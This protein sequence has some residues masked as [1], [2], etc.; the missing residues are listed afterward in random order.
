MK[1]FLILLL[2][3]T[4]TSL[5]SQEKI[6]IC[7]EDNCVPNFEPRAQFE[8]VYNSGIDAGDFNEE[9]ITIDTEVNASPRNLRM[10]IN[11][12]DFYTNVEADID[13]RPKTDEFDAANLI[14]ITDFL[15][16][17]NLK[18]DGYQ[19]TVGKPASQ[20]CAENFL[21]GKYGAI[22]REEFNA[23]RISD[24]SIS[25]TQCNFSDVDY[26]Q[27]NEFR[28]ED[29]YQQISYDNPSVSVRRIRGKNKCLG[30][31]F[32]D[33]C[34]SKTVEVTCTWRLRYLEP[35]NLAGQFST[36]MN[37]QEVKKFI[38]SEAEFLEK[39]NKGLSSYLCNNLAIGDDDEVPVELLTNGHFTKDL[40]EWETNS[41]ATWINSKV[42]LDDGP[43]AHAIMPVLP[44]DGL[45][46][47][48][49]RG[50]N[51]NTF[52][53]ESI[54]PN[55]SFDEGGNRLGNFSRYTNDMSVRFEGFI[56]P[57]FSETYNFRALADDGVRLYI[58]GKLIINGWYYGGLVRNGTS[59]FLEAG[60]KYS[61][62]LDYFEGAGR[63]YVYLYWWSANQPYQII[64]Q[65]AFFTK[66]QNDFLQLF[67]NWTAELPIDLRNNY[68]TSDIVKISYEY[69]IRNE[70]RV[71]CRI[72][73]Q[74][75]PVSGQKYSFEDYSFVTSSTGDC[76]IYWNGERVYNSR[77]TVGPNSC[78]SFNEINANGISYYKIGSPQTTTE[79]NNGSILSHYPIYRIVPNGENTKLFCKFFIPPN[80]EAEDKI[81]NDVLKLKLTDQ[82]GSE[83]IFNVGLKYT[84]YDMD[85]S[86]QNSGNE[87]AE[88]VSIGVSHPGVIF[89]P[90]TSQIRN[91]FSTNSYRRIY[92]DFRINI[93]QNKNTNVLVNL[94]TVACGSRSAIKPK[95]EVRTDSGI[96]LGSRSSNATTCPYNLNMLVPVFAGSNQ[97]GPYRVRV[98][99]ENYDEDDESQLLVNTIISGEGVTASNYN[100]CGS[101]E[102]YSSLF[103]VL[104]GS[105]RINKVDTFQFCYKGFCSNSYENAI[106][107]KLPQFTNAYGVDLVSEKRCVSGSSSGAIRRSRRT[108][109]T[110][111]EHRVKGRWFEGFPFVTREKTP[112]IEK[113]LSTD[114][115]KKY[116]LRTVYTEP[117]EERSVSQLKITIYDDVT[118]DIIEEKIL[119]KKYNQERELVDFVFTSVSF[120]TRIKFEMIDAN[121]YGKY[122]S[123]FYLDDISLTEVS[124]NAGPSS[125]PTNPITAN[126]QGVDGNG[127]FDLF[128]EPE[129]I[130]TTPGFDAQKVELIEGSD[131]DL[132]YTGINQSCPLFYDKVATN[133]LA[134]HI[135]YDDND[136]RCDDVSLPQDPNNVLIWSNIGFERLPEFGTETVNCTI[137]NCSVTSVVQNMT[138]NLDEISTT[139][140]VNGTNQGRGILM[141]YNIENIISSAKVGVAGI[142]GAKDLPEILSNRACV[143]IQD[144]NT[145]GPNSE[146]AKSPIVDFRMYDWQAIK[147]KEEQELG[148]NPKDNGNRVYIYKKMD[149]SSRYFLSKELL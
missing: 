143:K 115:N 136:E 120:R 72:D 70:D 147:V 74:R 83:N 43:L 67:G 1:L 15:K 24:P 12:N 51:F 56:Q 46:A 35:E 60:K 27:K 19:G 68:Q 34:L 127:Y 123:S 5:Y 125:P 117:E 10:S 101:M 76:S 37:E 106:K 9:K 71:Q 33:L 73:G 54:V 50:T 36:N 87:Q 105:V 137:G 66:K 104:A 121:D 79:S 20:I 30:V 48:V 84:V 108:F 18:L 22:A 58:D 40:D 131:W 99:F 17:I 88:M 129:Y 59:I 2:F 114:E 41:N 31:G 8:K 142:A 64:P 95:V 89:N 90:L 6:I 92:S 86:K 113:I 91:T 25:S 65:S 55:I 16:K 140:G 3:L 80:E 28:C 23:K 94:G 118:G 32:K 119:P 11:Q 14:F 134:S 146:F 81:L 78:P 29:G 107:R 45:I 75:D 69:L 111:Y 145:E 98:S 110:R 116:R 126:V 149:S 49:Y 39:K 61:F 130:R 97:P 4:N 112:H 128:G 44:G 132:Q 100:I 85:I 53:H 103:N 96:I 148:I 62:R 93:E 82:E 144:F 133:Y 139:S 138:K 109:T 124:L 135:G 77:T 7:A 63:E 13:L 52:S 141:S 102:G 21:S 26:L 38:M 122:S 42:K 57:R 47:K